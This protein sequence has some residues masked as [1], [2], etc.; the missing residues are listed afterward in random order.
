MYA[1]VYVCMPFGSDPCESSSKPMYV[2]IYICMRI[3][4]CLLAAS[5]ANYMYICMYICM[6]AHRRVPFGSELCKSSS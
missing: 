2:C 3:E 1:H 4:V 6:Y 5:A